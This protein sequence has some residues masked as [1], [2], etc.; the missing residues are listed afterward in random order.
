MVKQKNR[1]HDGL[2]DNS[3]LESIV[4]NKPEI[5]MTTNAT[6]ESSPYG[7]KAVADW[8]ERNIKDG[9]LKTLYRASNAL[10]FA[11][12]N[13]LGTVSGQLTGFGQGANYSFTYNET[14]FGVSRNYDDTMAKVKARGSIASD[15]VVNSRTILV[16]VFRTLSVDIEEYKQNTENSFSSTLAN[17]T[18]QNTIK[19]KD[20][21][22]TRFWEDAYTNKT[23][24]NIDTSF[25]DDTGTTDFAK[26][27]AING[28][29]GKE[30]VR[31]K[32]LIT[33]TIS[34]SNPNDIGVMLDS[35]PYRLLAIYLQSLN[36]GGTNGIGEKAFANDP[37]LVIPTILGVEI[38]EEKMLNYTEAITTDA[39]G[40][41]Y[42]YVERPYI[43][44]GTDV[45]ID[46][47][48]GIKGSIWGDYTILKS[49]DTLQLG[50]TPL[51]TS[52][53]SSLS[54]VGQ[55]NTAFY[56]FGVATV[57]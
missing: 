27:E 30:I 33:N 45:R 6:T 19:D 15:V 13:Y 39:D 31:L 25:I 47:I 43:A 10:W 50:V 23:T 44:A 38:R 16:D 12:G 28:A 17:V 26:G 11:N 21:F 22:S 51:H 56:T 48:V 52:E 42:N 14:E 2:T 1:L 35:E 34:G 36:L 54:G 55:T 57:A 37:S 49:M 5:R 18:E 46:F 24:T 3:Q 29:I 41:I 53:F 7:I 8:N 32:K 4:T 20:L 9:F 40:N